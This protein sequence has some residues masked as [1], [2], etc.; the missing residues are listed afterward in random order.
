MLMEYTKER[1]TNMMRIPIKCDGSNKAMYRY[2]KPTLRN[3]KCTF[4]DGSVYWQKMI[5]ND[6]YLSIKSESNLLYVN[7]QCTVL[8]DET[9]D[10]KILECKRMGLI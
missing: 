7:E 2:R 5:T 10:D 1:P 8:A 4:L 9:R 6:K 3:C